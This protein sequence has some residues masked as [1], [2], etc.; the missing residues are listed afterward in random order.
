MS[1]LCFLVLQQQKNIQV[2]FDMLIS[3]YLWDTQKQTQSVS[4]RVEEAVAC[5]GR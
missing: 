2:Q 1:F 4:L 3:K 5:E